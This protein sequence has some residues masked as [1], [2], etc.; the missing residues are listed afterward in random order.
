MWRKHHDVIEYIIEK[1]QIK[2]FFLL[3]TFLQ[4][5]MINYIISFFTLS[6]TYILNLIID[7]KEKGMSYVRIGS[8]CTNKNYSISHNTITKLYECF[9]SEEYISFDDYTPEDSDD[10]QKIIRK[11]DVVNDIYSLFGKFENCDYFNINMLKIFYLFES[12]KYIEVCLCDDDIHDYIKF[13]DFA[14]MDPYVSLNHYEHISKFVNEN[15]YHI[16]NHLMEG[17]HNICRELI[18]HLPLQIANLYSH[19]ENYMIL[20]YNHNP[21]YILE[22]LKTDTIRNLFEKV[23]NDGKYN[24]SGEKLKYLEHVLNGYV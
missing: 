1:K 22:I 4:P 20:W 10:F 19:F 14:I 17:N 2:K 12:G 7:K 23:L 24:Y 11:I 5:I 21:E 15:N 16:I 13:I 18:I 8:K 6:Y 3:V 9:H